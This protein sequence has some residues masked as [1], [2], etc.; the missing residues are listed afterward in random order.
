MPTK[1]RALLFGVLSSLAIASLQTPLVAGQSA[2][3]PKAVTAIAGTFKGEWTMFG[4]DGKGEVVKRFSWSDVIKAEN[5]TLKNDRA[6]VTITD[7]MTFA[8][9]RIPP[10][11]TVGSEGYLL[12]KDGSLGDYFFET[13]GQLVR[14]KQLRK[15]IWAY[16]LPASVQELASLGFSNV[17]SGEH[18]LV[19]VV[20]AEQ[21]VETH[22]ITRLTTVNWKDGEGKERW[23]QFISLQ[24]YHKKQTS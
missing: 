11:K 7:E 17:I 18:T 15:D 3:I 6:F 10:R 19:K 13:S 20:T 12:N 5:P 21:G 22:R 14:M 16:S 24:G 23:I 8:D 1:I 9:S 4:I 2:E